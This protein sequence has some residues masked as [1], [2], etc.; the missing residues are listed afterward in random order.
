MEEPEDPKKNPKG[1]DSDHDV[2]RT[3]D[4]YREMWRLAESRL[5]EFKDAVRK[6]TEALPDSK[7]RTKLQR[8]VEH[9]TYSDHEIEGFEK[10][11]HDPRGAT[12]V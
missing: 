9:A 5:L 4:Y 10:H 12:S 11:P 7:E 6:V 8:A 1:E 2:R 3:R